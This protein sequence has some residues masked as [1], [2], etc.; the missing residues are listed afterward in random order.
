MCTNARPML[1]S[2]RHSHNCITALLPMKCGTGSKWTGKKTP[3]DLSFIE[4][5][6]TAVRYTHRLVWCG[7]QQTWPEQWILKLGLKLCIVLDQFAHIKPLYGFMLL[8]H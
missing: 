2:K 7:S 8:T 3:L 4:I 1:S 6:P 5:S